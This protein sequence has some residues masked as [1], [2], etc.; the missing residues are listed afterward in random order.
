MAKGAPV[1]KNE[2]AAYL[3][4]LRHIRHLISF[5]THL[6]HVALFS[7]HMTVRRLVG[8]C[9][10]FSHESRYRTKLPHGE[11]C[12]KKAQRTPLAARRPST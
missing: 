10:R 3:R 7:F 12:Q 8:V 6:P 11:T 1:E 2:L 4:N 9:V 5:P